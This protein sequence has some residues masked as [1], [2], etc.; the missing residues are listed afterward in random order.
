MRC[1]IE[2]LTAKEIEILTAFEQGMVISAIAEKLDL[3]EEE[4]KENLER[5]R[6]KRD[7][8]LEREKGKVLPRMRAIDGRLD[9][10]Q[11]G[12]MKVGSQILKQLSEGIYTSPAGSLK[13]LISNSYDSDATEVTINIQENEVS[14]R[15]NGLGMDWA[16]FDTEFTFIS[17]SMKRFK[18][19]KTKLYERPIIGFIG[20]GFIAVSELCDILIIKSGK[21][22]S[23]TFFEAKIDFSKYRTREALDK[24]FYEVSEYE[25][26][27]YKKED[28]QIAI[29][30]SFTEVKLKDLRPGFKKI[31]RDRRPFGK[32]RLSMKDIL[33]FIS[34]KGTGTTGLGE[35]WQMILDLALICP[36][37]Y[38]KD[39][40]VFD[41]R[42]DK[43]ISEIKSYMESYNFK[44]IVDDMEL[45][46]PIQFPNKDTIAESE[47]YAIHPIRES[48]P[49]SEGNV[50]FKGYIYS[51]H[52]LINPR[53][54]IGILIRVK[55]VAVG[56]FD[57]TFLEYPS[58]SNQLFRN[59]ICGEIYI[60]EG[61]EGG[62]SINRN[63]FKVTHA[64]YIAL[65]DW[66]HR[67]LDE[68]VF[69]YIRT[70]YYLKGRERRQIDRAIEYRETF[71][72]IVKSELGKGYK[73]Q[74]GVLP[75]NEPVRIDKK[76]EM[77]IVNEM[78]PVF[79]RTPKKFE[80]ILERMLLLFEIAIEKSEGDFD[81]L[82]RTFHEE[83]E[84]W[85]SE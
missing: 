82:K 11:K 67:F 50:S 52:G 3:T 39:S 70:E 66:L 20:I 1:L 53:E 42:A 7:Q 10:V 80:N 33:K 31:I 45:V 18:G 41:T 25:L 55:N 83:I 78:Y 28:K 24:E 6:K 32:R 65:R 46:K 73:F 21:K 38:E 68:E 22:D 9:V 60:D 19:K 85:I 62:M 30:K 58:G 61:L 44:I 59:W 34:E 26:I 27:N 69:K 4:V 81:R 77:V 17:R 47:E 23:E 74:F 64:H 37:R 15:D 5:A 72:K 49:T 76:R 29:E 75:R 43:T 79:Y 12:T 48:I 57:R 54:Y 51:Q 13:E 8:L 35:Y 14:V 63:S 40:P 16:D 2:M 36:V 56:G 71:D 84:K